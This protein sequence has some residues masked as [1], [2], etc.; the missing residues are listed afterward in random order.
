MRTSLLVSLALNLLLITT[1]VVARV[2]PTRRDMPAV[3]VFPA[4]LV[5]DGSADSVWLD[6]EQGS[7]LLSRLRRFGFDDESSKRMAFG[8]LLT[9]ARSETLDEPGFW[10][11]GYAPSQSTLRAR[12][13]YEQAVRRAL[14]DTFGPV[15]ESDPAFDRWFRPLGPSFDFL[16]SSQQLALQQL[17][18]SGAS[19]RAPVDSAGQAFRQCRVPA[20]RAPSSAASGIEQL[21]ATLGAAAVEEYVLRVSPL[22]EQIR[23]AAIVDTEAQF[24]SV[25]GLLRSL[26]ANPAID[27]QIAVRA[28]LRELL[29][30]EGFDR[31]WS[32]RD[33]FYRSINAT[34]RD[35]GVAEHRI[36]AAYSIINRSQDALLE[37]V[38]AADDPVVSLEI[39]NRVQQRESAEL[40]ALLGPETAGSFAAARSRLAIDF[41]TR[42]QAPC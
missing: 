22:A 2:D 29:G 10:Q 28:E 14:I 1:I 11:A 8:W 3:D 24:R 19:G 27:N 30:T 33:P 42:S 41:S 15:A 13:A 18:L 7:T 6:P 25:F 40:D 34:L 17:S 20:G 39:A 32:A 37:A 12:F 36:G 31:L 26:E 38:Q 35:L 23:Q 5:T 9:A 21:E 16:D 4:A